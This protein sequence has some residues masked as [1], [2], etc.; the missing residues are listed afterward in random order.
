LV[1]TRPEPSRKRVGRHADS[2]GVA[3]MAFV[4]GDPSPPVSGRDPLPGKANYFAGS[5]PSKVEG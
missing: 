5:D 1:L 2:A 4:G 3:R